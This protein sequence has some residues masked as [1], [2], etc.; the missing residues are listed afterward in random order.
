MKSNSSRAI[1][2]NFGLKL[3]EKVKKKNLVS[4][5]V[6]LW[7][8]RST[9]LLPLLP[10]PHI[11]ACKNY[12]RLQHIINL[13]LTL[14]LPLSLSHL[15]IYLTFYIYLYIYMQYMYIYI[16]IYIYMQSSSSS[17]RAT[18]TDILD[19]LSP[20]LPIVH[21]LRQVFWVTSRVLT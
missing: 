19:H 21:H 14:S 6:E 13:S 15:S 11:Y 10:G 5:L 17:R 2:I 9:P 1:T 8:M 16:Y 18:S 4:A 3:L 7:G 20:L 12:T